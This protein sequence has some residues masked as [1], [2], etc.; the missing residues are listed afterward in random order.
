[1]ETTL[2]EAKKE[3]KALHNMFFKKLSQFFNFFI[4]EKRKKEVQKLYNLIKA[5]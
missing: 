5:F 3:G 4:G 1:M 2:V